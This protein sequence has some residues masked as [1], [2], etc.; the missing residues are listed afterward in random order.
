MPQSRSSRE[1]PTPR[2][3][4]RRSP[5]A[6]GPS[7]RWWLLLGGALLGGLLLLPGAAPA[8]PGDLLYSDGFES[9]FGVW[10]TTNTSRSGVNT[11]TAGSGSRSLFV[12]GGNV[13]TT[14]PVVDTRVPAIRI[15]AWV[16]RGS[17][18]FSED[19]D[20]DEDLHIEFLDDAGSWVPIAIY[21]GEETPGEVLSLDET[22]AGAALHAG[23]RLRLRM[24][25]GSGGPPANNG[26]GWDYWHLD[27]LEIRETTPPASFD[28]GRCE[29][30]EN[31]LGS[32][33]VSST[34]GVATVTS[35]TANTPTRSLA[36]RGGGVS[37]TSTPV[38]LLGAANLGLSVWVRRGDDA[39]SED[40]DPG[41]DLTIQYL[42]ASGSWV[43]LDRYRGNGRK[44]QIFTPS[45]VLP[46]SAAHT[47]F[48]LRF[49]MTGNDGAPWDYWHVD[50]VCL[51]GSKQVGEWR[52]E[53]SSWDGTPGEVVDATGNGHDGG[54]GGGASAESSGPAISGDPGTCGYAELDGSND[55]IEVPHD[56][57]LN[58]STALTY[59]AWI[60]P[61]SWSGTRQVM[62]KSV[63]GG[64]SGRA[65]MGIF[66]ESG[67]LS[68]RAETAAGRIDIRTSLPATGVWTHVA[69]VFEDTDLRLYVNGSEAA[70]TSFSATTLVQNSDPLMIGKRVGTAQYFFDGGIDEV[71]VYT[72]ALSAAAVTAVM[73][74]THACP[75]VG[76]VPRIA[77][78]GSG[79]HCQPE[80]IGVTIEDASGNTIPDY[81]QT[82]TLDTQTGTGSWSLVTGGGSF[83]DATA[84]DG[85]ALY[86]FVAG[87][88]GTA[89]FALDYS[90]GPVSVD[91][92]VIAPTGRDDDGEGPLVFSPSA[93]T[94]TASALPNPPPSPIADPIGTQ[95]AG[96]D[97]EIHI[98]AYGTTPDDPSCGVIESYDGAR[99]VRFWVEHVSP[100]SGPLVPTIETSAI[101]AS[102]ASASDQS[103]VFVQG[104]A[105]V[106]AKYKDVGRIRI[107]LKDV[108]GSAPVTGSTGAFVVR[109]ADLVVTRVVN[110][111]N[112]PNPGLA[113]PTGSHWARAGEAFTVDVEARDAEG[114]RTPSFGLESP[115]E[116]L[117]LRSALLEA[118]SG[119]RNGT[120][121]D[122]AIANGTAFAPG[123]PAGTWTGTAFAFDEVGAIRLQAS[124]ADGDYLGTGPL[125]GSVSGVV[126]RFAPSRFELTGN[127]PRFATACG[128][129]AFTWMDQPFGFA[130]GEAP[131]ITLRAVNAAGGTTANYAGT[132]WRLTNGTLANKA[133]AIGSGSLDASGVPAMATDPAIV[134]NGDGTG[135]LT[136][137]S[138]S[139]LAVVRGAPVAPFDAEIALSI[140]VLD[141][142]GTAWAGNPFAFGA[143]TA[144]NGIDFD[145]AKRVQYGRLAL[146][147][148]H[149]SELV[150]LP[151]ALR[152]QHFDG[153]AFRDDT[154]DSCTSV[155]LAAISLSPSP[156]TLSAPASI[157]NDPLLLGDAG[158]SLGA[159]GEVGT[160]DLVVDLG[161]SGANLAWLRYDW[162]EDGNLDGSL[163]D[164]PRAR[165]TF[166]IWEG[167]DGM[168]FLR[169]VY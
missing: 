73:N 1:G 165:A 66:S 72:N 141:A 155:P 83:S 106:D 160:V 166:G 10:T 151:M 142:D 48:R 97:F 96:T 144:G 105:V 82:V 112:D 8:A 133:Y 45:F 28:L 27:D 33:S 65:Q 64:G 63:H 140:D 136:F 99:P 168:I 116:G 15:Q 74:E 130:A 149:G 12:R 46:A 95:T 35:Q 156:G 161:P 134:S 70:S 135:T 42:N 68:G 18:A 84:D 81:D 109:P 76:V 62:A 38:D 169:D 119:G 100:A 60:R 59:T 86:T 29:E 24:P 23:F 167:R 107:G 152:V 51:T 79:V 122:G 26:I 154:D 49:V 91:V 71:R 110:A 36:I 53:E 19:T 41:E 2:R 78:D 56:P 22:L 55:Y 104:R 39:F 17:D 44:G 13:T 118:P 139:G 14:G 43:T 137:S 25:N 115:A 127:T 128:V 67:R 21:A 75:N 111:A 50:S 120:A 58:G 158:L 47:G 30:F 113:T 124:V 57:A 52:F 80:V 3:A 31:G 34:I 108:S 163:D 40:P 102:E 16:R 148:A 54:A 89:S 114:A 85:L 147:N 5:R 77:H 98:A 126:G 32:W 150:D 146:S 138:G 4:G 117:L 103:I 123:S 159:P 9:G 164:D 90:S 129:G 7:W 121:D 93:F 92:D 94:V 131:V 20:T 61:D 132:W 11:M 6:A 143:T 88:G 69:L 87:D 101:A 157:A 153:V 145:V 37:V 162:P 125:A